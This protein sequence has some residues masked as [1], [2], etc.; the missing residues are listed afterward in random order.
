M[1]KLS[2]KVIAIILTTLLLGSS[3]ICY[4]SEEDGL[5]NGWRAEQVVVESRQF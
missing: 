2:R 5:D 1:F 4:A 3:L